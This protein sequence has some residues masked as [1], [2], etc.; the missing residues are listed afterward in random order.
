MDE[1]SS[2]CSVKPH[3]EHCQHAHRGHLLLSVAVV[4]LLFT[5]PATASS[6]PS[7]LA[8]E[9]HYGGGRRFSTGKSKVRGSDPPAPPPIHVS[10][11]SKLIYNIYTHLHFYPMMYSPATDDHHSNTKYTCRQISCGSSEA[12]QASKRAQTDA[13]TTMRA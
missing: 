9:Q 4:A 7:L 3:R 1:R 11:T 10:S 12:T 13:A 6:E 8:Y 2:S 5:T